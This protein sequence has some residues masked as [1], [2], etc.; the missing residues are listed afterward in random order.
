MNKTRKEPHGSKKMHHPQ[1]KISFSFFFFHVPISFHSI[2]NDNTLLFYLFH[3]PSDSPTS[4]SSSSSYTYSFPTL[5]S[6][7][8]SP[9]PLSPPWF[10]SFVVCCCCTSLVE[11]QVP[12]NGPNGGP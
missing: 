2:L 11:Y 12:V 4:A 6:S 5:N 1:Q 10:V 9:P 3:R 7:T 8:T